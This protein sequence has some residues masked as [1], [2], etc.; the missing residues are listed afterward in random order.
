MAKLSRVVM[1]NGRR[2]FRNTPVQRL[3]GMAAIYGRLVRRAYGNDESVTVSFRQGIFEVPTGDITTLP[4][5]ADGTYEAHELDRFLSLVQPGQVVVDVGAN[6]GVWSV[7]LSRAV[8]AD[9]RVVAFEP[10]PRNAELLR[11]NLDRNHCENVQVVQAALGRVTGTGSLDTASPGASHRMAYDGVPGDTDVDIVSLDEYVE[12]HGIN[13]DA[14]KIDVEGYE[15]EAI[16]GMRKVLDLC[17]TFLTEFSLPH[18]QLAGTNWAKTLDQLFA[19]YTSCELFDGR[20]V[21][22][23]G[24]SDVSDILHSRKLINLLFLR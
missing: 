11:L 13:V 3:P 12:S 20:S 23:V 7:L 22:A 8:G 24:S 19:S 10:S 18:S 17:P 16:A 4:S 6:I 5:L 15:P 2:L 1:R 21:R 9:G 14:L